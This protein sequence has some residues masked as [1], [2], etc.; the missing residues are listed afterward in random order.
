MAFRFGRL[1]GSLTQ[2][3]NWLRNGVPRLTITDFLINSAATFFSAKIG[4]GGRKCEEG[5]TEL[6]TDISQKQTGGGS[7]RSLIME[8]GFAS[9][10]SRVRSRKV[11]RTFRLL[12]SHTCPCAR[13]RLATLLTR[14]PPCPYNSRNISLPL[15][16]ASYCAHTFS[17]LLFR[18]LNN[19]PKL[20]AIL[21]RFKDE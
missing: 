7:V 3:T 21:L 20:R 10:R 18:F 6:K 11:F 19:V 13:G 5:K 9:R 1:N 4:G 17:F 12:L 16:L 2:H 14:S 15:V 8:Q